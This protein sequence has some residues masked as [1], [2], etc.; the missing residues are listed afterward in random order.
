MIVLVG[1]TS[2]LNSPDKGQAN[3]SP[4]INIF[5]PGA[6][7]NPGALSSFGS[8]LGVKFTSAKWY[9]DW[10]N[11]FESGIARGFHSQ[12]VIP[13]LTW[14]PQIDGSGISY[15]D[16]TAGNY[17][18]YINSFASSV[19]SLGFTIRIT[20]AP[21]MNGDWAPW[22]VGNNGNT[23][24]G[25]RS[26]WQ[27]TVQKFRDN[28]TNNVDWVWSPNTHYWGETAS[29]ADLYPGD[30]YVDYTGIEGYNWGT[31]QSWSSWQ[32]FSEVF[33]SSYNSLV[34]LT[35]KRILIT[36]MAS[37]ELGGSKPQWIIDMFSALRGRFSRVQGFTWFNINKETDWRINSSQASLQA[38]AR[39][40]QGD[41]TP[42]SD[43]SQ[44]KQQT[45]NLVGGNTQSE[46]N[47]NQS[48]ENSQIIQSGPLA[49]TTTSPV[50]K[51]FIAPI[52]KVAGTSDNKYFS[53]LMGGLNWL[54]VSD[55]GL[56]SYLVSKDSKI[57]FKIALEILLILFILTLLFPLPKD[58][59]KVKKS[60]FAYSYSVN[61]KD[62][63][64]LN[65]KSFKGIFAL[66]RIF[67]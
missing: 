46:Q 64:Y 43:D 50:S 62:V 15:S 28:G 2:L 19:R 59:I 8:S 58:S 1:G 34:N 39:A 37:T 9:S 57:I 40:A 63:P 30:S 23:A 52:K 51:N 5:L 36:E 27:Y 21:E 38:F 10:D 33:G 41:L 22:G 16:V 3:S 25:F 49:G 31:S 45:N 60:N 20:L 47:Q 56:R 6:T 29:Y 44:Q 26:F 48:N 18:N 13:E 14:Q 55:Y 65:S 24:E 67:S 54:N 11:D 17:D 66:S 53:K 61:V 12:G 7:S 42:V 4:E 35:G 32:S